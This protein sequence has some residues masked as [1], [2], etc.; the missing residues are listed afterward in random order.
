MVS[1]AKCNVSM[2]QP[3]VLN[4]A[5]LFRQH[6]GDQSPGGG[7]GRYPD[8]SIFLRGRFDLPADFFDRK[9][10]KRLRDRFSGTRSFLPSGNSISDE[11]DQQGR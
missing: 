1:P 4:L 8:R 5:E 9:R 3:R 6:P 7:G 10:H 11:R 2:W